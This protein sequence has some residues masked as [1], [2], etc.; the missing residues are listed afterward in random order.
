MR[1]RE[2]GRDIVRGR[3]RLLEGNLTWDSIPGPG[4]KAFC[5]KPRADAQLLSYPG[6]PK[7]PKF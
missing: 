3:S 5:P 6:I 1:D 7:M 4:I 2:R